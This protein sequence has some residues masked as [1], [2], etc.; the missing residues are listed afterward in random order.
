[1]ADI[2][3]YYDAMKVKPPCMIGKECSTKCF[4]YQECWPE[5]LEEDDD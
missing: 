4:Y 3:K 1:M 5:E 2:D